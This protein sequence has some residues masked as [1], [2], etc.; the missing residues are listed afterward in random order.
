M[1]IWLLNQL[2]INDKLWYRF[3]N[4]P[5][6]VLLHHHNSIDIVNNVNPGVLQNDGFIHFHCACIMRVLHARVRP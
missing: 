6:D 5:A 2:E 1:Y 4:G 3:L